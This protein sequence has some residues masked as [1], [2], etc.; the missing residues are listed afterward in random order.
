MKF[1]HLKC[2]NCG[3]STEV[4]IESDKTIVFCPN[5]GA[6]TFIDE[7]AKNININYEYRKEDAARIKESENKARIKE[8]ELI[9]KD[10]E[11]KRAWKFGAISMIVAISFCVFW[12]VSTDLKQ[13]SS[14]TQ[15]QTIVEEIQVD[16]TNGNYDA[17]LIKAN[18]LHYSD[19]PDSET[20]KKWRETRE[21]INSVI[22][23]ARKNTAISINMLIEFTE[24]NS[25]PVEITI[26][27]AKDEKIYVGKQFP[28][29]LK[30]YTIQA[31]PGSYTI[32]CIA[33]NHSKNQKFTVSAADGYYYFMLEEKSVF[34]GTSLEIDFKGSITS[35]DAEQR[36]LE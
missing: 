31:P 33:G 16:I 36:L 23:D 11:D 29:T 28:G 25:E 20:G 22:E 34:L 1:I 15:L 26:E 13:K 3:A 4:N 10:K 27:R 2:T 35:A 6:K 19:D 8:L 9:H 12:I 5:C 17:A 18:S 24:S 30:A 32:K 21:N 7:E 14:E